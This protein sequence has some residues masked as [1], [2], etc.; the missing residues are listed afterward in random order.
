MEELNP[1]NLK[2]D[3]QLN[4]KE[5]K[6]LSLDKID[7]NGNDLSNDNITD[8]IEKE[9]NKNNVNLGKVNEVD[10]DKKNKYMNIIL[11]LEKEIENEKSKSKDRTEENKNLIIDIKQKI[12]KC[13]KEIK[14]Y[15][16]KNEKQREE[17]ELLSEQVTNQLNR[18]D[19][20]QIKKF[21]K[22][23]KVSDLNKKK[24]TDDD[25]NKKQIQL[26]NIMSMIK[27]NEI[28]NEKLK[29]KI[30]QY[31]KG[32]NNY[33][34]LLKLQKSQEQKIS[35]LNKEI[36]TKKAQLEM[37]SKCASIKSDMIK[38]LEELRND[39]AVYNDKYYNS[40]NKLNILEYKN[41]PKIILDQSNNNSKENKS[42]N[43]KSI[44]IYRNEFNKI[45]KQ[46]YDIKFQKNKFPTQKHIHK[47]KEE[48][49]IDIPY[50]ITQIFTEK[51]LK[52]ILVG[53]DKDKI[54]YKNILNKFNIQNTFINSLEAKHKIDIK[55]KLNKINELD[56]KI[57][58]MNIKAQENEN[59]IEKYVKDINDL[60]KE[61]QLYLVKNN[62][63]NSQINEKKKIVERKDQEIN[64][65]GEQLIK[66]KQLIKNGDINSIKNLPGIEIQYIDSEEDND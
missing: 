36:K 66:L 31:D 16:Y 30:S 17:L 20:N 1:S 48:D 47:E 2:Q 10:E 34:E 4:Q 65:L 63:L 9:I 13:Q 51:E 33:I 6:D 15:S 18:I 43:L 35:E 22:N 25:I 12:L 14:N 56:E 42:L 50:N 37:H 46:I 55:Q 49:L 52:A 8:D 28:E 54:R 39:I 3:N 7:I 45:N 59:D 61:K 64:L 21:M 11:E 23:T 5:S 27:N 26:K 53:L 19:I 60:N 41:K 58:F 24:T 32:E 44:N 62:K 38:K 57:E 29:S 40:Q